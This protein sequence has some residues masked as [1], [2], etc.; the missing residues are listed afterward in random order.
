MEKTEKKAF[1]MVGI[2]TAYQEARQL[3]MA[4]IYNKIRQEFR[5]YEVRQAFASRSLIEKLAV[6]DGIRVDNEQQ[7]LER[8]Q[9]EGFT[10][11]IVQP[12]QLFAGEEYEKVRNIVEGYIAENGFGK[13]EMLP[14]LNIWIKQMPQIMN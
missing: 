3:A 2:G 1:L 8:L 14:C 13:A 12:F 9:A 11:V 5:H 4:G 6:N 10:E 7:A